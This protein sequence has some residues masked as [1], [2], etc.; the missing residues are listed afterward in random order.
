[1]MCVVFGVFLVGACQEADRQVLTSGPAATIDSQNV[2]LYAT[3][4]TEVVAAVSEMAGFNGAQPSSP[5]QWRAFVLAGITYVDGECNKYLSALDRFYRAKDVTNQQLALTGAATLGI[6]GLVGAAAQAVAIVGIAFGLASATVDNVSK[7]LIYQL[8][9]STVIQLVR[10]LQ[11][12]YKGALAPGYPDRASAFLAI[13]GYIDI[14]LP[15]TIETQV[16][17]AVK[18]AKPEVQKSDGILP[19]IV[20]IGPITTTT[21]GVDAN[22]ALLR[23]YVFKADNVTMDADKRV[24]VEAAMARAGVTGV[25]V[26][27][28]IRAAEYKAAREK[29]VIDLKLKT[30]PG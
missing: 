17:N 3:R 13:Q 8:P 7:G 23:A 11:Q 26:P 28:F 2:R 5:D 1:M 18:I 20:Q 19:P 10:D 27:I 25:S 15:V 16:A 29:V 6:L 9:A 24:A 4:Q 21:F 14:C 30:P 12:G 22:T